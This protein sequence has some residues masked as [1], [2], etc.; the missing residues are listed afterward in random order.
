MSQNC[1]L[2]GRADNMTK[3]NEYA[4]KLLGKRKPSEVITV[5]GVGTIEIYGTWNVE[6]IVKTLLEHEEV[7]G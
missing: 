4:E 7:T 2:N 5:E 1:F 6:K 3:E